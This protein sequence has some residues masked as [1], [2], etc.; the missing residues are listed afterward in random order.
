MMS[1]ENA[2]NLRLGIQITM[3][4]IL[5]IGGYYAKRV[6]DRQDTLGDA[7]NKILVTIATIDGNR[8]TSVDAG[9][10]REG[11]DLKFVEQ[12]KRLTGHDI[13]INGHDSEFKVISQRLD[14]I[15]S[16]HREGEARAKQ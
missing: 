7:I 8:F 16:Y 14:Q 3:A 13:R 2:S 10:L 6:G 12:D 1:S 5:A 9:K 4:L 11:L 15:L